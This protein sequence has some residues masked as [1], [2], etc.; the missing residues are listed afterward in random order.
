MN[1]PRPRRLP[2]LATCPGL[3]AAAL[4]GACTNQNA[5]L[6]VVP[7]PQAQVSFS[8]HV[9]PILSNAGCTASGCHGGSVTS[10]NMSL[11]RIFDP[12]AG[13]VGVTSCEA[14]PLSR[15]EPFNGNGSYLIH[16][17]EGTQ[18]T[19]TCSACDT[20]TFG[21]VSDCGA[22]M[23]FGLRALEPADIKTIHDWIDQGAKDN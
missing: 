22:Q 23:P 13:A 12:A 19:V 6:G 15:I 16:K 4:L 5:T 11:E 2:V 20:V 9:R 7:A 8:T 10:A 3:V 1:L 21:T 18:R 17:L 14:P